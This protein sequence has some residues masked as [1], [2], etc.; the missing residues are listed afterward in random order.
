MLVLKLQY[1]VFCINSH[2]TFPL[3]LIYTIYKGDAGYYTIFFITKNTNIIYIAS[4]EVNGAK[5]LLY[6]IQYLNCFI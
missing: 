4:H 2:N 1:N 6:I 5:K 3:P